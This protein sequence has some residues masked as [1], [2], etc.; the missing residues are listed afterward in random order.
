MFVLVVVVEVYALQFIR[1]TLRKHW[2]L[3]VCYLYVYLLLFVGLQLKLRSFKQMM[4]EAVDHLFIANVVTG[5]FIYVAVMYRE[6]VYNSQAKSKFKDEANAILTI[7]RIRRSQMLLYT[8]LQHEVQNAMIAIEGTVA[9]MLSAVLS[10]KQVSSEEEE[11]AMREDEAIAE[12]RNVLSSVILVKRS[13]HHHD[14]IRQINDRTYITRNVWETLHN[15]VS[16]L[17]EG[18]RRI[19]VTYGEGIERANGKILPTDFLLDADALCFVM[20]DAIRNAKKYGPRGHKVKIFFDYDGEYLTVD[21]Q[22]M[23]DDQYEPLTQKRIKNIF[24]REANQALRGFV[25]SNLGLPA[26]Y[27]AARFLPDVVLNFYDNHSD[28]RFGV[29]P[30]FKIVVHF[31]VKYKCKSRRSEIDDLRLPENLVGFAIDDS[32]VARR[33][34]ALLMERVLKLKKTHV[35]GKTKQEVLNAVPK[36]LGIEQGYEMAGIVLLDQNIDFADGTRILGTNIA[37]ILHD[38]GFDGLVVILTANSS[39]SENAL[40]MKVPGVDCVCGKHMTTTQKKSIIIRTWHSANNNR[41]RRRKRWNIAQG[42][43]D[44]MGSVVSSISDGER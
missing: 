26:A 18:E 30:D 12:M 8:K 39:R 35:M 20:A 14:M 15:I 9:G 44:E 24:A 11:G 23:T 25:S 38:Q 2:H 29:E 33:T 42:D 22:N 27:D 3:Q 36:I 31:E 4:T 1:M 16:M 7:D 21:C 37:K 28:P 43:L 6:K 5:T 13:I 32:L 41:C 34:S 10:N 19:I 17:T 40:Y